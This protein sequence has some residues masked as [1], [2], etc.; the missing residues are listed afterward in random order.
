MITAV[1][2]EP[3]Q[4]V[5]A[6]A[7]VVRLAQDGARDA[8]FSVPE[9]RVAL[10]RA[11][12]EVQVRGWSD[13]RTATGRVREVAASAD[14]VT[15]TFLVKVGLPADAPWA[16]G[17]T[18]SV[19]PRALARGGAPV[20]KLPTSAL[21]QM[22]DGTSVWVVDRATMT[23]KA[24]P[25]QVTTADGNDAVIGSGLQPGM[26]VVAAGVHVLSPGEK[27]TLWQEKK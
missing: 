23:V 7:P 26:L 8:V 21:R 20:I 12:S 19:A 9:D 25:V 22:A 14:P 27:V 16:L 11:G 4:V 6:G 10:M 15:R 17:A 5:S 24:Q 18:V 13:E 1:E 3:G 2:A